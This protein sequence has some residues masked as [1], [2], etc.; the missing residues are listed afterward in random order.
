MKRTRILILLGTVAAILLFGGQWVP[1]S[2]A[3]SDPPDSPAGSN[4][5]H[6]LG[7]D[8]AAARCVADPYPA[9]NGIALDTE[10]N[11]VVMTDT[12][13]KSLL[14]YDRSAGTRSAEETEPLRQ[15]IGPE[16]NIGFIAGVMVDPR[17]REVFAVNNDIEDT[18]IVMSC[19]QEGNAKPLRILSVP[20]Q[21]WGLALSQSRNEIAVSVEMHNAVVF[22]R[23][24]ASGLEAPLRSIRGANTGLADPHGVYWDEINNEIGVANHG[25]FRGLVKNV[26]LGCVPASGADESEGGKFQPPS[27]TLYSATAK[28]DA[29]PLHTIQGEH[30]GLDWPMGI[31]VD[32]IHN[33]I[34]VANNGDNSIL[35][36]R[37]TAG[38]DVVP[39]RVIRGA[40]TGVN[41]PM[42]VTIDTKNNEIW[43]ANFGDHT[44]VVFDRAA[45]GNVAPKR[46]IR[47]APASEPTVGFGNPMAVAYDS[48]RE[49]ILVPN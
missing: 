16:T 30:T 29:K 26:G 17:R 25:N 19:D 3:L 24:E 13:R 45:N 49:Q 14:M 41:R 42:G 46:I 36:F 10:H 32:T 47:N 8:I 34:A 15:I 1:F 44:A 2:R 38:G 9:F 6:Q 21:A 35:M 22:Y 48:K 31:S 4:D 43:V 39:L 23:R 33:E 28:D 18:M 5:H 12:N 40:R 11:T 20:H 7:G 27:I 37:R